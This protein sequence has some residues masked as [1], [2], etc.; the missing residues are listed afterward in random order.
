VQAAFEH[1]ENLYAIHSRAEL[2]LLRT[3]ERQL[4]RAQ[5]TSLLRLVSGL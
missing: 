4:S 1:F 2:D 3:L 5:R